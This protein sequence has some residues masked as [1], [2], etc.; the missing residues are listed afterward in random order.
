MNTDTI[1]PARAVMNGK[2]VHTVPVKTVLNLHS[3][4]EKKL[5]CDGPT[6]SLGDACVYSCSFCYVPAI[7][8]KM[9]RVTALGQPHEA[10][11]VR[12]ADAL[13]IL[14]RQLAHPNGKPKF[15]DPSDRRVVYS[16]PLVDCA[17]NMDLV[18]ETVGACRLI[19]EHTNWQIRLLSKSNLLPQV[20]R[21]LMTWA[22]Q[23]GL[24]IP[25]HPG[26]AALYDRLTKSES[27]EM[28][29][30]P[31]HVKARMIFGVSTGTLDDG[32]AAAFEQGTP[33]VSKRIASLHWLQDHGF[34][35]FA[36]VC[37][38]LP[39]PSALAYHEFA[40][41]CADTLRTEKCE[42]VYAE[43]INV[44]GESMHRTI[45]ALSTAGFDDYAARLLHVSQHPAEW[46]RYN[47][48]TFLAH[49]EVH[50]RTP[51]KLRYLTY[52]TADSRRF[53]SE[54]VGVGAVLL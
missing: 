24:E 25:R 32:V 8:A 26:N 16:S 34:R 10:I 30:F 51:G 39:L 6:F 9:D 49:A 35:T 54:N 44:R 27:R 47:R 46:E 37:P 20:A 22:D 18:R 33:L 21:L 31:E 13:E 53:W 29:V 17:G 43:V 45:A 23:G 19:L 2:P 12:R 40:G 5:L 52:T 3:G 14:K 7:M 48:Y 15:A 41:A 36:M 1:S 11:V 28:L 50:H 42:H 4:F 38:S